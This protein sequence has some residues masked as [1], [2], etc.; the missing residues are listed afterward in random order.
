I[1]T[2]LLHTILHCQ[3]PNL[4]L[5]SCAL[6]VVAHYLWV[7]L[8]AWRS[9]CPWHHREE[10]FLQ[11]KK[12]IKS[13]SAAP[14]DSRTKNTRRYEERWVKGASCF[15]WKQQPFSFN[16]LQITSSERFRWLKP[17][18]SDCLLVLPVKKEEMGRNK[19]P[20]PAAGLTTFNYQRYQV[21]VGRPEISPAPA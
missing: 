19:A 21:I 8:S 12:N 2:N 6:V 5:V 3:K 15:S 13:G 4:C 10:E 7:S 16:E 14:R 18:V 11:K 17:L 1:A 20:H 9:V